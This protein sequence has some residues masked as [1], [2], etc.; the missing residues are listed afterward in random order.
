MK[1]ETLSSESEEAEFTSLKS[2]WVGLLAKEEFSGD[3]LEYLQSEFDRQREIIRGLSIGESKAIFELERTKNSLSYRIGRAITFPLRKISSI[4]KNTRGNENNPEIPDG[5]FQ[6]AFPELRISPELVPSSKAD[7][8]G[9]AMIQDFLMM[10]RD[11]RPSSN[12]IRDRLKRRSRSI[13]GDVMKNSIFA[14]T[15]FVLANSGHRSQ[16]SSFFVGALRYLILN[17]SMAAMEYYDEYS[18]EIPDERAD[19]EMVTLLMKVGEMKRPYSILKKIRESKWKNDISEELESQIKLLDGGFDGEV[20]HDRSKG[21]PG[22]VMYCASQCLPHTNNGYAIRTHE[23]VKGIS[24]NGREVSVCARHGYPLD[25]SDFS[26]EYSEH[27]NIIDGIEYMFNPSGK[28]DG[29][30]EISYNKVFNFTSFTEYQELY[31]STLLRQAEIVKPEIIHAASNFVVGMAAVNV[32]KAIGVPSVY[33]IR[34]FWHE[35]QASKRVAYRNSDHY[36]LSES[37]EI[38]VAKRADYVFTITQAIADILIEYGIE[39]EKIGVLPNC[40]NSDDF[41]PMGRDINL[42]EKY[43]LFDKVVI[44]YIGSFV[45]YE[46]LDI[47]LDAV[48]MIRDEVGEYLKVMLVGDGP[49]LP[50]VKERATELGIDDLVIFTGRIPH[51]EVRRHY[52]VIDITPFPRRGRRV[53]ELVSPLKPFEALAMEKAVIVSDVAALSEII[54]HGKTGLVHQKD[55]PQSLS[56]CIKKLVLDD[57]DRRELSEN[58]RK[59]VVKNRTWEMAGKRVEAAYDSLS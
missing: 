47:L 30:P 59:W 48:A 1:R 58:G 14:I 51:N 10:M 45:E 16:R 18:K 7:S 32:A 41:R 49:E 2:D 52:S 42:E 12:E 9:I 56:G 27:E 13:E 38:E 24:S 44:G 35:T 19:K 3:Q 53:C 36:N 20:F 29:S 31:A 5:V 37:M 26:G 54:Q 28:E 39:K 21:E 33:E 23:V 17:D 43:E 57:R 15:K 6:D 4:V 11:G 34:G 8:F 50:M 46:G 55:D 25:R 22:R 40:V